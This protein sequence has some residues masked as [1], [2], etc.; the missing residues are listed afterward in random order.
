MII[1]NLTLVGTGNGTTVYHAYTTGSLHLIIDC[2]GYFAD[3]R[4]KTGRQLC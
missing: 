2:L 1:P 3:N 4:T